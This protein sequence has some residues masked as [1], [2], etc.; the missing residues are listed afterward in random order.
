MSPDRS[1]RRI[2]R[3]RAWAAWWVV[4]AAEYLVLVDNTAVQELVAGAVLAAVGATAAVAVR[5]RRLVH[6]RG[7]VRWV[8]AGL[9]ALANVVSDLGPLA[10]VLWRRG[11]RRR[12]G[13]G[14]LS[15][16]PYAA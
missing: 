6:P 4:C 3:A 11:V 2:R 1:S 15:E 13:A 7:D 10:R 5:G 12:G 8:P 9:R 16:V 14:A